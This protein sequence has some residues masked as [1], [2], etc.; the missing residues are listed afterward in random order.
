MLRSVSPLSDLPSFA[1]P[2]IGRTRVVVAND[3]RAM[4]RAFSCLLQLEHDLEVVGNASDYEAAVREVARQRPDV[5]VLDL[6]MPDGSG[7]ESI[8]RL[9]ELSPA[10]AL[11]VTTMHETE[12]Y[13][14]RA[15]RAGALGFVL[16]DT[17]EREL[18]DAVRCAAH[19]LV[20]LSRGSSSPSRNRCPSEPALVR[21]YARR[22]DPA[23]GTSP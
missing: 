6:R 18:A 20:Y 16:A 17:A 2:K 15:L 12:L 14:T 9:H 13:A 22:S 11:V 23:R 10:T 21:R 8:E 7:T 5:L 19:G 1:P 4:G 3:H